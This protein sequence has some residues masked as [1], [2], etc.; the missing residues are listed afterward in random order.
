MNYLE[1]FIRGLVLNFIIL[2]LYFLLFIKLKKSIYKIHKYFFNIT[3]EEFEKLNYLLMGG[4]KILII[5]FYLIPT[6]ILGI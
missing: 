6:L 3:M 4:Y 2:L 5:I 1:F